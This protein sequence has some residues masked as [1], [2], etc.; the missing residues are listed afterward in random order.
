MIAATSPTSHPDLPVNSAILAAPARGKHWQRALAD[1]ITDPTE[2]LQVLR[3]DTGLAGAARRAAALFPLRVPRG[4]VGRMKIGDVNDPLLRQVLPLNAELCKAPG[5]GADPV[6]DMA[7]RAAPGVLHKY[8]GRALLITTGACAVHCR[9][10]FRR[11]FPYAEE[12]TTRSQWHRALQYLAQDS[13]IH[14]VILSGGD[15]LNLSDNRLIEISR[16]IEAIPHVRRLRIHTRQPIVLPERIDPEFCAWLSGVRL[17]K[18]IVLHTNHA[19]EIDADVRNAC[20]RLAECGATLLNQSVLLAGVNDDVATL[21]N[22][23]ESLIAAG[24]L[25]YYLHLLDRVQGS[26]HFEVEA[27]RGVA[28]IAAAA[29]QL[30]GYLVP[31]LVR[32]I[33]GERSKTPVLVV[34]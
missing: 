13:S 29:E 3:L 14:E 22:L 19:N 17:Q 10:C 21:V 23:S 8:E 16:D 28:L 4:F 33:P 1:A 7:S 31:K 18:V 11:D 9:Y 5:F 20:H 15:P 34:A 6:G 30:P 2:L 26:A 25:P 24:V 32:E 27:A 12:S